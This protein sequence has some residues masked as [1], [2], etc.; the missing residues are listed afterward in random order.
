[1]AH[2]AV[3]DVDAL[4]TRNDGYPPD[5]ADALAVAPTL[6]ARWL[7]RPRPLRVLQ[8]AARRRIVLVRGPA[9]Y[10]KSALVAHWARSTGRPIAWVSFDSGD[11]RPDRVSSLIAA[12]LHGVAPGALPD[13]RGLS[14]TDAVAALCEAIER[15]A[16][17]A[18]VLDDVDVLDDAAALDTIRRLT[19]SMPAGTR[20][21]AIARG[22][23]SQLPVA[24]WRWRGD[25]ADLELDTLAFT[26]DETARYL[27]D[28]WGWPADAATV[29]RVWT[30][31]GGWP[32]ALHLIASRASR[33]GGGVL[34]VDDAEAFSAAV[35]DG[36][37]PDDVAWLL[38]CAVFDVL[39]PDTCADIGGGDAAERLA[40]LASRGLVVRGRDGGY[41][42]LPLLRDELRRQL[43][44]RF[45]GESDRL[46]QEV[47]QSQAERGDAVGA[48][49]TA[50]QQGR[51]ALALD[52]L[53]AHRKAIV[54]VDGGA[55]LQRLAASFDR[56][57]LAARPALVGTLVDL[58]ALARDIP[59]LTDLLDALPP[60]Y[61]E[62][63]A[64]A[65]VHAET[66]L[67]RLTGTG[68]HGICAPSTD[69]GN[70]TLDHLH[71]VEAG[72]DGDHARAEALLRRALADAGRRG[73]PVR[74]LVVLGDLV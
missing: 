23:P 43:R 65:A 49:R 38:R 32:A 71:G 7:P 17:H 30:R 20:T 31:T 27:R 34:D 13:P 22:A 15:A 4:P 10:G 18:L 39:R 57:A 56:D 16:V 1:M 41:R 74:Q 61:D 35:L 53:A 58:A 9:G 8:E 14:D 2:T 19:S 59:R 29:A 6:P 24:R 37:D 28:V 55:T 42:H 26:R 70:A 45:P 51:Q 21:I 25:L 11:D 67:A 5:A 60:P 73:D 46:W 33:T 47:V 66:T 64:A 3:L 63:T 40:R 68:R 50:Q 54:A 52:V 62:P 48:V 12:A 36:A 69:D 72:W 44:A